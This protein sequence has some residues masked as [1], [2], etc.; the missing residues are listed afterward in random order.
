MVDFGQSDFFRGYVEDRL[1]NRRVFLAD[2]KTSRNWIY[3]GKDYSDQIWPESPFTMRDKNYTIKVKFK[4]SKLLNGDYSK[5]RLISIERVS[6]TP[7][8]TK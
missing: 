2:L 6:G 8:I 4:T 7:M 5:P 3:V 1:N